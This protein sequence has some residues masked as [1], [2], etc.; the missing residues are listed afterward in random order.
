MAIRVDGGPIPLAY[1]HFDAGQSFSEGQTVSQGQVLGQLKY[2]PFIYNPIYHCGWGVQNSDQYHLHFVFMPTT[3]GYLEI[4][5]CVL[6]INTEAFVCNGSTYAPL[7]WIPNGGGISDPGDD[8]PPGSIPA[9]G[10][11]HIW[12][13]IVNAI[14]SMGVD[15]V[16]Q[17]LPQQKPVVGYLIQKVS[18][19]V[20]AIM[21]LFMAIYT[22][23]FTGTL[24]LVLIS[25]T[26]AMELGMVT[27]MVALWLFRNFAWL[28]KF[29]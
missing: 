27:I 25:T 2:G 7:S 5:G 18:L 17:Y 11:S 19:I 14:V 23:G 24:L 9:G 21:S 8:D 28:L 4:G 29:L 13:G 3:P 1:F 6:D 16:S 22:F 10:G 20:Q 26:I 12:D 15:T